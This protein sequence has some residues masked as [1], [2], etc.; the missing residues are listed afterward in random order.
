MCEA[1]T[2]ATDVTSASLQAILRIRSVAAFARMWTIHQSQA[3]VSVATPNLSCDN[4][5]VINTAGYVYAAILAR[6]D[7]EEPDQ[8]SLLHRKFNH[9]NSPV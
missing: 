3:L 9:D 7:N 8:I 1:I 5:L 6:L 2:T 4:A